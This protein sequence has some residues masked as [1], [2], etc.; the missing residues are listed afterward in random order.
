MASPARLWPR[1]YP[2]KVRT[3]ALVSFRQTAWQEGLN[4]EL[5]SPC[6][7]TRLA[8]VEGKLMSKF[9]AMLP[10]LFTVALALGSGY[11]VWVAA[12][13]VGVLPW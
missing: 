8:D 1:W 5:P 2:A 7:A 4:T 13:L 10:V 9:A 6:D 3:I 12:V 11:L